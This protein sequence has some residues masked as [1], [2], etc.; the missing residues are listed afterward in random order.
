MKRFF[1]VLAA[2]LYGFLTL[3]APVWAQE[4]KILKDIPYIEGSTNPKQML[5][6]YLPPAGG[7][8]QPVLVFVHGGGWGLGDK[9][10][11]VKMGPFYTQRGAIV[12]SLNYRLAP[13]NKY[14]DFAEDLAAAMRWIVD[15]VGDY[16]GDPHRIVLSGHSAG[17]HLVALLGTHPG[18]L[19]RQGLR[20]D[21]FRAVVPVDTASFDLSAD[22][23]G[24]AVKRQKKMHQRA[25]GSEAEVLNDASPTFQAKGAEGGK[26]SPF[27]IFVS[28]KR[29][30]AVE[31]SRGLESAL[32][33]SGN[34]GK[35]TVVPGLSH[36][37]MCIAIWDKKS[38]IA[39]TI[40][41]RLGI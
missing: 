31:Q 22:P 14:P 17:A 26:L 32:K 15:H 3:S 19:K 2:F 8:N 21:M 20:L 35:V 28:S 29:P 13:A 36:R 24:L 41:K 39:Q 11:A 5:D 38:V 10:M 4:A 1:Y 37:A 12:I 33:E 25:F 30:D 6:I 34:N 18:L 16:G 40:M 27:D 23:Y 9:K 7:K